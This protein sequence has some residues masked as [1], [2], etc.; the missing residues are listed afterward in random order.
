MIDPRIIRENLD[1]LRSMLK[2]R[3]VPDVVDLD[4]FSS[5][6][7]ERRDL[8]N[9]SDELREKRNKLSKE[10]GKLKSKGENAAAIPL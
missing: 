9:R 2:K 8:M 1:G 10:I 4:E 6:D 5:V 7:E 3:C